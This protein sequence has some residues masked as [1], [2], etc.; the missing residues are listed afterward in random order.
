MEHYYVRTKEFF[1]K[2]GGLELTLVRTDKTILA[3]TLLLIITN[4]Y[5]KV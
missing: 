5:N 3:K 1:G 2:L 4:I